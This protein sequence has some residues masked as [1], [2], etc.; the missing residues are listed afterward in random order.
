LIYC[1]RLIGLG[2]LL[3][4]T[5]CCL[6]EE[7]RPVVVLRAEATVDA[8]EVLLG[9]IADV[10]ATPELSARLAQVSLGSG[11]LAGGQRTIEAGYVKLRLRRFGIDPAGVDLQGERVT[12]SSAKAASERPAP[13]AGT[14]S[15][16]TRTGASA[17]VGSSSANAQPPTIK[18][19]QLVEVLVQC[20]GVVIHA[21]GRAMADAATGE[22]VKVV[23]DGT[24][25]SLV[26][27]VTGPGETTCLIARS[28]P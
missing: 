14:P 8:A 26:A 5:A 18:R 17:A 19:S 15:P 4:L 24:N 2:A 21:N 9:Q 6:A 28:M 7:A 23:L 12:V 13:Q 22:W 10:Q 3:A 11:P 20:G 25:R 1:R 16:G 27:R